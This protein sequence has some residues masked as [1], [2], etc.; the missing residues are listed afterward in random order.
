M[1]PLYNGFYPFPLS[2]AVNSNSL[3]FDSSEFKI[4]L[5]SSHV[6]SFFRHGYFAVI[7]LCTKRLKYKTTPFSFNLHHLR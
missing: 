7:K 2:R 1:V 6:M 4:D 3:I 5:Y